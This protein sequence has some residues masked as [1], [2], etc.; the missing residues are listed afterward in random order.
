MEVEPNNSMSKYF[1]KNKI[2]G[3][4]KQSDKKITDKDW[5]LIGI[6]KDV[7]MKSNDKRIIKK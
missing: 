4:R 5:I 7:A 6:Y 2:D 1:Y 3:R